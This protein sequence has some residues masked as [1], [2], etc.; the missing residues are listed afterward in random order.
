MKI[1]FYIGTTLGALFALTV[2]PGWSQGYRNDNPNMRNFYMARQQ[3]QITDDV[4]TVNDMRT[5]AAAGTGAPTGP[6]G[7][8]RAGFGSNMGNDYG[9]AMKSGLPQVVNGVPKA[10]PPIPVPSATGKKAGKMKSATTRTS[11][12]TTVKTYAPYKTYST[13]A[14]SG[15]GSSLSSSG[16]VRGSVLHWNKRRSGY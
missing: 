11:A 13:G 2:L 4:P 5:G 16:N 3:I 12:P 1:R 9:A 7:L 10:A 8:P 6:V 15:V 14:P